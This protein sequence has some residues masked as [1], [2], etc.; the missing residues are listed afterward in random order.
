LR[1]EDVWAKSSSRPGEA[2]ES[3]RDH[4]ARVLGNLEGLFG[5]NRLLG[6]LAGD[7]RLWH[8]AALA[9][10]VHDLGKC[11]AGFQQMVRGGARFDTRH[12][13]LS[14]ALLRPILGPDPCGDFRWVAA[15]VLSHHRDLNEIAGRY[16]PPD[17]ILQIADGLEHPFA[18]LEPEYF[19]LTRAY[20]REELAS[21]GRSCPLLI[22]RDGLDRDWDPEE[23]RQAGRRWAR[24]ALD[25][26]HRLSAELSTCPFDS[27]FAV[28]CRFVRG[29]VILADH[30]GSAREAFR[31]LRAL[32][33]ADSMRPFM[34]GESLYPHQELAAA[35]DGHAILTAPTG[36]GK[37]EAALLWS[38]RNGVRL[39]A[40]PV[41]Y[42]LPYQASLNAMRLRLGRLFGDGQ[43]VLQHGHATLA[44][45][46]QLLDQGYAPGTARA[47]A[48]HEASLARL[49]VAPL[50]V[51]TPY[52]LLKGAYQLPGHEALWTDCAGGRFVLDEMHAYEPERF[53]QIL[54]VTRHLAGTLG[55]RVFVMSATL[56]NAAR[57][58]IAG[59]LEHHAVITADADTFARFRRHRLHLADRDLLDH[60]TLAEIT[61]RAQAGDAVLAVATTVARAQALHRSLRARLPDAR[62]ELLHGRFCADDRVAKEE[63]VRSLVAT[64]QAREARVPVV[65]VA[66]QVVEV[67]LDLDFDVLYSD[68][69]PLE[70]LLQ[71]FG[72]VNRARR[73]AERD[74]H[75]CRVVPDGSP[76]YDSALVETTLRELRPLDGQLLDEAC[77]QGTL[78]AVYA[79]GLGE[80]WLAAVRGAADAFSM[81]VLSALKAFASD[82]RIEEEF[83]RQFDGEEVLARSLVAEYERRRR[84][85]CL[86]AQMLLVPV[87]AQQL[88]R[89]R[90]ERRVSRGP[91][92]LLVVDVPY[93]REWGLDLASEV[94]QAA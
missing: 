53:G 8:R 44:L 65:V 72:R 63:R 17:P 18:C 6:E 54:A 16:W 76:V 4:T 51:L 87:R 74:V 12:E 81:R 29:L 20:W 86:L 1:P 73:H 67:S 31:G 89:L 90:R 38:A 22:E 5:R 27:A 43:I 3:L 39:P 25:A 60:E 35:T 21:L 10:L 42:V 62:M 7:D 71:R 34:T 32:A 75:V 13:V 47:A 91:D 15:A 66:T 19:E 68:P 37:T 33:S 36:S 49:H 88:A 70:A 78:D 26:Y 24:D 69:A 14:C 80:R 58:A 48:T 92:R 93:S 59:A 52:Q 2:G 82:E 57:Q 84:D 11:A 28:S 94:A 9:V 79:G 23:A 77:L 56:P 45:Y 61:V 64:G 30:S 40:A 41:F 50:R 83:E 55:A 46:R 85:D